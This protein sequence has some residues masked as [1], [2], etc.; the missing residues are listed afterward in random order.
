MPVSNT[1]L[2]FAQAARTIGRE[3]RRR[4]LV[5]PG[6]RCPPR[7][8][9]VDRSLRRVANGA[10]VAV[11]LKGRPWAAIVGDMIEGVIV[12]NQ[13]QPPRSDRLRAELWQALG[14]EAPRLRSVA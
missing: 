10:V 7:I 9:G 3:V 2:D 14:F 5:A 12:T 6:F 8:A 4:G 11:Q 1:S 13:L